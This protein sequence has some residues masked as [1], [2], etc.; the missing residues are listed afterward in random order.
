LLAV[1]RACDEKY[2]LHLNP[3]WLRVVQLYYDS[4]SA[5]RAVQGWDNPEATSEPICNSYERNIMVDLY[6][7]A[8]LCFSGAFPQ[9]PLRRPG[10]L[11]RFWYRVG[12]P[13]RRRI[14]DCRRPCGI[15]HS[16]RRVQA[17]LKQGSP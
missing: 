5:D 4:L 2:R 13:I 6:G 9:Y 1:L 14:K 8:R 3:A 16:V 12:E 15:S 17:T 10:D 11:Y 7:N